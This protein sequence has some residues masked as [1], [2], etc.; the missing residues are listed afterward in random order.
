MRNWAIVGMMAILVG[1]A[2]AEDPQVAREMVLDA[3]SGRALHYLQYVPESSAASEK[4]V[5]LMLFLHGAGERGTQLDRVKVHGPPKFI[6]RGESFPCIVLSPQCPKEQWWNIDDLAKLLDKAQQDFKVD[7]D[8]VYVTG[9][10]MGGFGTWALAAAYPDRFAAIAPVCGGGKTESA[11]KIAHVPAWVF[12]GADD[13][14][15]PADRSR[16]MVEALK[17]AG[18]KPRYTEYPEVGHPSW[19]PAYDDP[20]LW[21]WMMAQRRTAK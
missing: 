4:P 20:E 3:S 21:E 7:P 18:G 13:S 10:S 16:E 19:D 8:R 14:V 5:A 11:Q 12:H 9:L 1:A 15:V 17:K 6:A 2:M